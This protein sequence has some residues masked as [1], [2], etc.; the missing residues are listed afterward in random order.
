MASISDQEIFR[1][2]VNTL[3]GKSQVVHVFGFVGQVSHNY[4]ALQLRMKALVDNGQK[5]LV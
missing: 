2:G 5:K 3:S 4:S 1:K